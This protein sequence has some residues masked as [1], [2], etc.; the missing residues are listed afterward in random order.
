MGKV[1]NRAYSSQRLNSDIPDVGILLL[2]ERV[3]IKYKYKSPP[4]QGMSVITVD[5]TGV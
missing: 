3:V 1:P 2:D 4:Q 5:H